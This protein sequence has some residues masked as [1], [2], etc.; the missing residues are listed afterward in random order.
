MSDE[1][2]YVPEDEE[3]DTYQP[4]EPG[5][6]L[7]GIDID[8]SSGRAFAQS[9]RKAIQ[10]FGT[11]LPDD[12]QQYLQEA[13][14]VIEVNAYRSAAIQLFCAGIENLWRRLWDARGGD[15]E[16][17]RNWVTELNRQGL[18]KHLKKF[19]IRFNK[20][21]VPDMPFNRDD[22][23]SYYTENLVLGLA[24]LAGLFDQNALQDLYVDCFLPRCRAAHPTA[25]AVSPERLAQLYR[26]C[27]THL[28]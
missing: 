7:A 9:M 25:T 24:N 16:K 20:V 17:W 3:S 23:H 19:G 2:K 1:Y 27:V 8:T 14:D 12:L 13:A 10:E 26:T 28:W 11:P 21:A 6:F 22:W 15:E 5:L 18:P 4:A